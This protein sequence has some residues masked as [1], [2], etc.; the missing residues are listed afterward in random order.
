[1][2]SVVTKYRLVSVGERSPDA[3][4]VGIEQ[5]ADESLK[6]AVWWESR[7]DV[8]ADEAEYEDVPA[9]LTAAE[10][11]RALHGFREVVIV[12]ARPDLW[13]GQWGELQASGIA[14]EPIGDVQAT[15]LSSRETFDLA[16]SIEAERD[17]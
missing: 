7:G 10:A 11:A 5:G 2:S 3:V 16:A 14:R 6:A 9:A 15:D 17:A 13:D 12:L 1:M 8:D 4:T